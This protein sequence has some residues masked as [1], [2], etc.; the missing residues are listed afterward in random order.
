MLHIACAGLTQKQICGILI[1]A[2]EAGIVNILALRGDVPASVVLPSGTLCH[3]DE[4]VALIR[5]AHGD[6]FCI[7]VAGYPQ[8][9]PL[10]AR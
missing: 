8:G 9:H 4:L 1:A 3:A 6:Y 2:R 7:A 5:A 10:A